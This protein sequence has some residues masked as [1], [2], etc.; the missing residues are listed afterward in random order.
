MSQKGK[1]S[2]KILIIPNNKSLS[3]Y[4]YTSFILPFKNYSIGF[5]VYFDV[6]EIN[7]LSSNYNI[8]IIINK[9]MHKNDI[10][11][12]KKVINKLN[13]IK[14]FFIEDFGLIDI[15]GKERVILYQNHIVNNYTA[16]NYL[17]SIGF[18]NVVVSNE[19]TFKEIKKIKEN[20]NS[21]LYYFLINKNIIMYSKRSLLSNYYKNYNLDSKNN[22]IVLSESLKKHKL[23]LKEEEDQ[24][25][26]YNYDTF[27]GSKYLDIIKDYDFLIVNLTLLSEEESKIILNNIDNKDLYSMI[28][29][30]YYFLENEIKYKVKDL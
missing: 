28:N 27:C 8:Y 24:S 30:D 4:N 3:S 21:K 10:S 25:V 11:E 18:N 2:N 5:D 17:K 14:G 9:F 16:I 12:I 23:I 22:I 6:N 7:E 1:I 26:I 15:I 20:T 19:L 29:I 13:N